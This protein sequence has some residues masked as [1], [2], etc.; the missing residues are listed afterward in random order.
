MYESLQLSIDLATS[1]SI[2]F[3]AGAFIYQQWKENYD[4]KELG[5]W[6][7]LKEVIDLQ[8]DTT[9]EA[10]KLQIKFNAQLKYNDEEL[11]AGQENLD[12]AIET[13]FTEFLHIIMTAKSR[14][15]HETMPKIKALLKRQNTYKAKKNMLDEI[16]FR[17]DKDCDGFIDQVITMKKG[18]KVL[19]NSDLA[20]QGFEIVILGDDFL[21]P[22]EQADRDKEAAN[23]GIE[24]Y[25]L[26]KL[27][28]SLSSGLLALA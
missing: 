9:L 3:A 14:V 12:Y 16:F 25:S 27:F 10:T 6:Q 20:L 8:A 2:I 26:H 24:I 18:A 19:G 17:F 5:L 7:E 13:G 28:E 22:G 4:K 23:L 15:R 21:T 11:Q 1:L